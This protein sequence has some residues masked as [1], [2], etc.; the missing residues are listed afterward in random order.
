MPYLID[1]HNLIPHIQGLSLDQLD[2]EMALIEI[3]EGFFKRRRKKAVLY[4]DRAQIGG[5]PDINSAFL[6]IHFVRAP[7]IAD[8]AIIQHLKK[9][10][11]AAKNWIVVSSDLHVRRE[12]EKSGA[13]ALSSAAFA[14]LI[15][16]KPQQ[17]IES[18]QN[19][20]DDISQWLEIFG[21]DS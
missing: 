3:L 9:L 16:E 12:A 15:K 1:G 21:K 8:D 14:S 11:G 5:S 18:R 4:F 17:P 6:K 2:D 10:G 7:A 20:E 13:Q 19:G